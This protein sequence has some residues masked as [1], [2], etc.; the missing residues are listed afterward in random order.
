MGVWRIREY[1]TLDLC[2]YC[3]CDTH[4]GG[5]VW[6][7]K[8]LPFRHWSGARSARRPWHNEDSIFPSADS[9]DDARAI[10]VA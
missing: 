7:L 6:G 1:W 5:K 3:V 8:I 2:Y 10:N 4:G 9:G